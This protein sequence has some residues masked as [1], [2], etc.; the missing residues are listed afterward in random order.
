[1][2]TVQV[3]SNQTATLTV[4]DIPKSDPVAILLQKQDADT[5]S[6]NPQ[7][8]AR[9]ANAEFTIKYFTTLMDANPEEQG[10]CTNQT[11]DI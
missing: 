3:T 1:M 7:G 8:N 9:L 10:I 11:M 6:D 5:N 2:H 4:T